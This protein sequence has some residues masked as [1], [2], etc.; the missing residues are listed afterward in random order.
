MYITRSITSPRHYPRVTDAGSIKVTF[1]I[2]TVPVSRAL[3]NTRISNQP[4]TSKVWSCKPTDRWSVSAWK[5]HNSDFSVYFS[6]LSYQR[7]Y[8]C[9]HITRWR[10]L[11]H[12][13][14]SQQ[15]DSSML[16]DCWLISAS[17]CQPF[18]GSCS[19]SWPWSPCHMLNRLSHH[20]P[21]DRPPATVDSSLLQIQPRH[22]T[23]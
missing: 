2:T 19:S 10:C 21:H 8:P 6:S 18:L 4:P 13:C 14:S 9:D 17:Q 12:A 1:C 7:V 16:T 20:W 5:K 15:L 23:S 3:I 22:V 11:L